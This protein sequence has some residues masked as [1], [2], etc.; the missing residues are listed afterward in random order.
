[1]SLYL[2]DEPI[3]NNI[4]RLLVK[5]ALK[6]DKSQEKLKEVYDLGIVNYIYKR[7][8]QRCEKIYYTRC[9]TSQYCT[10]EC[11]WQDYLA[12]LRAERELHRH[13]TCLQCQKEFVATRIDGEY[14]SVACKQKAYRHRIKN[15]GKRR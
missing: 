9:Y 6:K 7:T 1:M 4:A 15:A 3:D 2:D 13:K 10:D 8:C 12:R 11:W 5:S 14:C